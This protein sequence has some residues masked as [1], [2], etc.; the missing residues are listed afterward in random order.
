LTILI[1]GFGNPDRQDDGVAWHVLRELMVFYGL[2]IPETL[3]IDDFL[4][5]NSVHFL[6]QLQLRPEIADD[7][8]KYD[9]AVFI[10]AHT[11]AV[12]LNIN[13]IEVKPE[14]QKSP[15]THHLTANSLLAIAQKIHNK[16]P[17]S[18]LVSIRGYEFGFSQ[19]LSLQSRELVGIAVR[20]IQ[21]WIRETTVP[22]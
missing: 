17:Y 8:N 1:L 16:H 5:D 14:F 2:P 11:G 18:I 19:E 10:D 6:F 3:D 7:L 20:T 13:V 9:W 22:G 12:P 4:P 21:N 15:L